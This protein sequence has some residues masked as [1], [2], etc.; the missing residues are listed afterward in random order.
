MPNRIQKMFTKGFCWSFSEVQQAQLFHCR[1]I[2]VSPCP[3]VCLRA[4]SYFSQLC[5]K[6]QMLQTLASWC[7]AEI[8]IFS[9]F[10]TGISSGGGYLLRLRLK[11]RYA[12]I[13]A[14]FSHSWMHFRGGV[15]QGFEQHSTSQTA[16]LKSKGIFAE[17]GV[18]FRGT[19]TSTPWLSLFCFE[20]LINTQLLE[21]AYH[22]RISSF[23]FFFF[24]TSV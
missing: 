1:Q 11:G 20:S 17:G 7:K 10:S 14:Y 4:L 19:D 9:L 12:V 23:F 18:S 3:P 5:G 8:F 15:H 2:L 13:S 16:T 21:W 22:L 6:L 24:P